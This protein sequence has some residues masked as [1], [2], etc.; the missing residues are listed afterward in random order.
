MHLL[1]LDAFSLY[2]KKIA[3]WAL[4]AANQDLAFKLMQD[5]HWHFAAEDKQ[6]LW[7]DD[8]SN[9]IPLLKW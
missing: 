8:Y 6:F 4:L 5:T 3:K 1:T 2:K 7:T 9:L